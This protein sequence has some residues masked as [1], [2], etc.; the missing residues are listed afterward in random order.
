M[1]QRSF[2]SGVSRI[3]KI[4]QLMSLVCCGH[5]DDDSLYTLTQRSSSEQNTE[6]NK[7][8]RFQ[9][10][11]YSLSQSFPTLSHNLT[12]HELFFSTSNQNSILFL[13]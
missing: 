13:S 6:D 4:T 3:Q 11:P 7:A 5:R 10:L 1:L 2:S 12:C 9:S 8:E